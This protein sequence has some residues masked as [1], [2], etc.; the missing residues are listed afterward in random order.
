MGI[1]WPNLDG[2]VPWPR[3]VGAAWSGVSLF[4]VSIV[5]EVPLYRWMVYNET[6]QCKMDENWG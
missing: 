2:A 6:S 5:M 1:H 4:E 3:K